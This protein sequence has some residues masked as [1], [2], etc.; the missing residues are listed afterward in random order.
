MP[1]P[2]GPTR[3]RNSPSPISMSS[4][5]TAGLLRAR[6]QPGGLVEGHSCHEGAPSTGRYV[7]DDPSG[8]W[9]V[10][11]G[12]TVTRGQL[13]SRFVVVASC[14]DPIVTASPVAG[15]LRKRLH[16]VTRDA[17]AS[18]CWRAPRTGPG[19]REREQC[20]WDQRRDVAASPRS[21]CVLSAGLVLAAC[22]G[23]DGGGD[24]GTNNAGGTSPGEGKAECEGLTEFGDLS[25]KEVIVYTSIV[26]PEDE[27]QKDSYEL[28]ESCTGATVKYEGSKEFEAQ[29]VV[30]VRS[31]N[32][33][34]IAN[35]PQPGLLNTLVT[36]TGKVEGSPRVRLG[37]RRRVVGRGLEGLRHRRRQV[38]RRPAGREREVLR[39]VLPDAVRGEGLRVP[40]TW[41]EMARLSDTI[42]DNGIKPWC[43]GIGSGEATG[44]PVDRLARGRHAP[45]R[46]VRT[47]TTSGST[48]EIPFDDPQVVVGAG[49]GRQ[50]PEERQVRQRRHR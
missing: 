28:F 11:A 32:P 16:R 34:D 24:G 29:L 1:Q 14:R 4:L 3:T 20:A 17:G 21:P 25:G 44:W 31:G 26:A 39:L 13:L 33:P 46:R 42:A 30:R 2:E 38:L 41:D 7:P 15:R 18:P 8:R 6:E 36:D 47:P 19:V 35:V 43:A 10:T 49:P 50:H 22:G 9:C 5:S 48:H 27:T 40:T 12:C 45:R 37:Q 23:D